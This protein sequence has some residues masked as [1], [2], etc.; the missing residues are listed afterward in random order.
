MNSKIVSVFMVAVLVVSLFTGM[1]GVV[2]AQEEVTPDTV[3][4]DDLTKEDVLQLIEYHPSQLTLQERTAV[5]NWV[6]SFSEN[7]KLSESELRQAN[8]W[9]WLTNKYEVGAE[10]DET[11]EERPDTPVYL[12]ESDGGSTESEETTNSEQDNTGDSSTTES[13]N[14]SSNEEVKSAN[15]NVKQQPYINKSVTEQ[16]KDDS[17]IYQVQG[18]QVTIVTLDIDSESVVDYGVK[19][20]TGSFVYS[21]KTK[22]YTLDFE[23]T[24]GS[25]TVY[26]DVEKEVE[27]ESSDGET[28]TEVVTE[29]HE[30]VIV[31]SNTSYT[32]LPESELEALEDKASKWENFES[33]ASV[34]MDDMDQAVE[35]AITAI[36]F[37]NAPLS[38]LSGGFTAT[39]ISMIFEPGGNLALLSIIGVVA[40]FAGGAIKYG[41]MRASRD[42]Y[43]QKLD[44][45]KSYI[46]E[47]KRHRMA[48]M[49]SMHEVVKHGNKAE[50]MIN[51][52]GA[53]FLG[54]A[55]DSYRNTVNEAEILADRIQVMVSD[56]YELV[57][58]NGVSII[59]ESDVED[60]SNVISVEDLDEED[61]KTLA[62][63][64]HVKDYRLHEADVDLESVEWNIDIQKLAKDFEYDTL[65][66]GDR[67]EFN[68]MLVE[69][70]GQVVQHDMTDSEGNIR[71]IREVFE[72]LAKIP[73]EADR[74]GYPSAEYELQHYLALMNNE[75]TSEE[76][77]KL[78]KRVEQSSEG[79][80]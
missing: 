7:S 70:M 46:D 77:E 65:T 68:E 27:K 58:D 40:L 63:D 50:K 42:Q 3:T 29:T 43:R 66:P 73:Q 15:I 6:G 12:Q 1:S 21:D 69:L 39:W 78:L 61:F 13:N 80:Q 11:W 25:Y 76:A 47:D 2:A 59:P 36:A 64:E 79:D 16:E 31:A 23:G 44:E 19:G 52:F 26:W 38:A 54:D 9:M 51:A 32:H 62:K 18:P 57:R 35:Y 28:T 33:Q 22:A 53:K 72:T 34:Y 17:V 75:S 45:V 20:D 74:Y 30:A 37:V 67:D 14:E 10:D 4:A 48:N 24:D 71:P 41:N 56:S 60:S 55:Y 49:V 8:E 5:V